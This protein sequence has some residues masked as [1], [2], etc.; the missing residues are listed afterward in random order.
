MIV[1][2]SL[3]SIAWDAKS[4]LAVLVAVCALAAPASAQL[5]ELDPMGSQYTRGCLPPCL[6]PILLV[7]ETVEGTFGLEFDTIEGDFEVFNMLDVELQAFNFLGE[8]IS[9]N[10]SGTYRRSISVLEHEMVL[11][12][13]IDGEMLTVAT[14]GVVPIGPSI[15]PDEISVFLSTS[16]VCFGEHLSL[17]AVSTMG[18]SFVRM[19]CNVDGSTDIGDAV[20]ALAFL[21]IADTP[22]CA[23]ACDANDDEQFDVSDAIF[24][25]SNLFAGGPPPSA[26][27]P[28][29]GEDPTPGSLSCSSFALCP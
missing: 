29:C 21:F 20:A 17:R 6:C 19:D 18:P 27:F 24:T 5:Y 12:L 23:A 10:G 1:R 28:D 3:G 22:Q 16:H 13:M 14:D 8:V 26:P 2:R 7:G 4:V 15:I 9:L 25:L 11:D